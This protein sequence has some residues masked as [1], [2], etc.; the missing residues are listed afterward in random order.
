MDQRPSNW[1]EADSHTFLDL[2]EVAVPS[3]DEQLEVLLSLVPARPDEAFAAVDLCCGEGRFAAGLLERFP[4]ALVLALDGSEAMLDRARQRLAAFGSR[5]EVRRFDL[6]RRDWL[7]DL[8][9]PLRC[10]VSSLALHHLHRE[11]KRRLFRDLCPKLEPG[12]ALLIAD[13]V[14]PASEVVRLSFAAAWDAAARQ[15]SLD[16]T[17]SLDAFRSARDQRWNPYASAE[18]EPGETPDRLFEQLKWLEEAGFSAV[19]C[20]WMRAGFAVYG[21]YR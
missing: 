15:R 18:L 4:R 3:R 14:E 13:I 8:P 11:G 19:D 10:V 17:G 9:A 16:L 1:T 20:F 12:G 21:G 5:A 6:D 7:D 2:A